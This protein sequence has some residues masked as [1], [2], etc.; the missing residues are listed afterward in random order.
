MC[1]GCFFYT[2]AVYNI[3]AKEKIMET[4]NRKTDIRIIKTKKAIAEA[5]LRLLAEK[6]IE[7]IS[8]T[9]LAEEAQIN[10]K[11][12]YNYY[13][14][15]YQVVEEI[16]NNAVEKFV[17]A[18][19]ASDWYNGD[20]L[21][22]NKLF[23]CVTESVRD[24]MDFFKHLLNVSKTSRLIVKVE[25]RLKEKGKVYFSQ[26]LDVDEYLIALALDYVISGMFSVYRRWLQNGRKISADEV[27]K[28]IG[29]M[30]LGAV[31]AMLGEYCLE[32]KKITLS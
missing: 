25:T 28:N 5:T 24:N 27:A 6:K 26:Y 16:E 19:K 32:T 23:L 7:E 10:R 12:F 18:I 29:I 3:K 9:E 20:T 14:S 13:Q 30:S 2:S 1:R 15:I 21:D 17:S 11:T 8:I 22:F 31:N 4:A